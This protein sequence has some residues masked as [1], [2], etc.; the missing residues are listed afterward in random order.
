MVAAAS[1]PASMRQANWFFRCFAR[2][3]GARTPKLLETKRTVNLSFFAFI[4]QTQTNHH[5]HHHHPTWYISFCIPVILTLTNSVILAYLELWASSY[6]GDRRYLRSPKYD[7]GWFANLMH[8]YT[9]GALIHWGWNGLLQ[10]GIWVIMHHLD[11]E[12]HIAALSTVE[13]IRNINRERASE[14]GRVRAHKKESAR[15]TGQ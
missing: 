9:V 5:P 15:F 14:R 8:A 4:I 13:S 2:V 3:G 6:F 10:G 7:A 11:P 12:H 1:Q